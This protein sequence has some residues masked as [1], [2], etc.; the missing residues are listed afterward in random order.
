MQA[1]GFPVVLLAGLVRD[2]L[3]TATTER[4][5]AGKK[6]MEV[7]QMRITEAGRQALAGDG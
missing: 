3:A 4:T 7:T 5:F 2:G 6:P 1:H